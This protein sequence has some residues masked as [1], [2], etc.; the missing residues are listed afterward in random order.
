MEE[1]LTILGTQKLKLKGTRIFMP[2]FISTNRSPTSKSHIFTLLTKVKATAK[3]DQT[4]DHHC[5]N[6]QIHVISKLT[7]KSHA[8][9]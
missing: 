9:Q 8:D 3:D 2:P 7:K 1:C 4:V 6:M 5:S